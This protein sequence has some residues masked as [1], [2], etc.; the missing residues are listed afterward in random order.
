MCG[1]CSTLPLH[2]VAVPSL[3]YSLAREIRRRGGQ[4]LEYYL[5]ADSRNF[6]PLPVFYWVSVVGV[7]GTPTMLLINNRGIVTNAWVGSLDTEQQRQA[8]KAILAG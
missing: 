4:Y 1:R 5:E 2:S 7:M 6:S 8:F 3:T